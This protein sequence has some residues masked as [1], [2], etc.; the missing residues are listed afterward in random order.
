MFKK[1]DRSKPAYYM[2]VSLTCISGKLL[3]HTVVKK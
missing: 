2:S 1:C 3:D